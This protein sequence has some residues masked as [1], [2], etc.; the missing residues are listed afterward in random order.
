MPSQ[1]ISR[2]QLETHFRQEILSK[3]D[4]TL[5]SAIYARSSTSRE[6]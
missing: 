3:P 1:L 6:D 5:D 4:M 2:E